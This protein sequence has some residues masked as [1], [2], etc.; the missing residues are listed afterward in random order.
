MNELWRPVYGLEESHLVS[1]YGRVWSL[2]YGKRMS[3]SLLDGRYPA[4]QLK[5]KM[6]KVH[7]LVAEAFICPRPEGLLCLHRDDD[8]LNNTPENLYWGTQS[9]NQKDS[10]RNGRHNFLTLRYDK[11]RGKKWHAKI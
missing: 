4:V 6:H 1:N 3:L 7:H 9:Q 11:W 8:K 2:M 10:M 5:G